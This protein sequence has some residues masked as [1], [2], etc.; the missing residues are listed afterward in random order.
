MHDVEQWVYLL[1]VLEMKGFVFNHKIM[2]MKFRSCHLVLWSLENLMV[3]KSPCK[4][5]VIQ[6][7]DSAPYLR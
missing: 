7:E 1:S 3:C 2:I 4:E 5:L 6:G